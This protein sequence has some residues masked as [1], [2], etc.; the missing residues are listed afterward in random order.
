MWAPLMATRFRTFGA[1]KTGVWRVPRT[2]G[3][4]DLRGGREGLK[5][6]L[7]PSGEGHELAGPWSKRRQELVRDLGRV[8]VKTKAL[9]FGTYTLS[10][11]RLSSYYVDLRAAP[12]FPGVFRKIVQAYV[13]LLR[14]EVG[15]DRLEAIG[16]VPMS[17]LAFA[18]AVAY[19]LHKPLLYVRREPKLHGTAR[20]V[21]GVLKPGMKVLVLDDL[22]TTGSS[23]G[24]AAQAIRSGGGTVEDAA[25]LIDRMEGGRKSLAELNVR[26][27]A[28]TTIAEL[29]DLLFDMGVIGEPQRG[30]IYAQVVR[31][32]G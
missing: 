1:A 17:G 28:L 25:V 14:E 23:I 11:G 15:L 24:K 8:L 29:A 22:V 18:A 31:P 3:S 16:G 13:E 7:A 4:S 32:P 6:E 9:R 21:E 19:E 26:L 20:M 12:S 27:S 5:Q 30:A 2:K 10:S